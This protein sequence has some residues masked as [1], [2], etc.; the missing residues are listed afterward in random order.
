MEPSRANVSSDRDDSTVSDRAAAYLI[1]LV[2]ISVVAV[3]FVR[4]NPEW[5]RWAGPA[6]LGPY[7]LVR[8]VLGI[9]LGKRLMRLR[10][11]SAGGGEAT[12]LQLIVRNITIAAGLLLSQLPVMSLLHIP[13]LIVP[14]E[15]IILVAT[16]RR[17]GDRIAGTS[18]VKVEKGVV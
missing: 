13:G 3:L 16:G 18:V 1:D 5:P 9:S 10:V 8:D 7:M 14:L 2:P 17:L 12:P 11:I 4:W 15:M 6:M